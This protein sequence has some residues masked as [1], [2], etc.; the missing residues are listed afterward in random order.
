M[1]GEL[2]NS[3]VSFLLV[4][5]AVY[6]FVILPMDRLLTRIKRK[7]EIVE[8]TKDCPECLSKIPI[9]AT[10]CAQCGQVVV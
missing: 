9:A 2:I 5:V 4:A 1:Y 8:S 10:R 3:V 7:E 6:F